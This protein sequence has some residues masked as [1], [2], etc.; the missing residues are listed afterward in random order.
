MASVFLSYDRE[1]AERA[2]SVALAL[3]RAGHSV[4]WD[5]HIKGGAQY[6]NEIEEALKRADAV[7][8]LWSAQSV[9]S[10]WVRDEAAAGRDSGRLVPVRLDGTDPP[11]GFRQY[12]T[13]DL[14]H[15]KGRG[16]PAP[17]IELLAAVG[18]AAGAPASVDVRPTLPRR[19]FRIKP[20][21]IALAFAAVIAA[22][23]GAWKF[24]RPRPIPTV[25]VMAVDSSAA[26]RNLARDLA[27][28]LARLQAVKA[29]FD[30][31]H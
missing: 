6:S 17:L 2:R 13:I 19:R 9:Q 7:V 20:M 21:L 5:R 14:S 1:D 28:H 24:S 16:K 30:A 15:W 10:A 4:W 3:E 27:I 29:E 31:P 18:A 12:Q 11:L 25:A 26:T 22:A 23:I 8:V